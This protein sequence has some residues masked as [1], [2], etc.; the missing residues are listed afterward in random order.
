MDDPRVCRQGAGER[1]EEGR[2]GEGR[3]RT[4]ETEEEGR[5][6]GETREG[7]EG[8]KASQAEGPGEDTQGRKPSSSGAGSEEKGQAGKYK[9]K[10]K[11][12]SKRGWKPRSGPRLPA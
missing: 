11:N 4:E 5:G 12:Q 3:E 1:R 6:G 7:G 9:L 8:R 2:G 10:C